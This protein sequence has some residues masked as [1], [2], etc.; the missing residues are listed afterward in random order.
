MDLV[1]VPSLEKA[2]FGVLAWASSLYTAEITDYGTFCKHSL[3]VWKCLSCTCVAKPAEERHGNFTNVAAKSITHCPPM[4]I[5][6]K[7]K[8]NFVV[9]KHTQVYTQ[10]LSWHIVHFLYGRKQGTKHIRLGT[11]VGLWSYID[12]IQ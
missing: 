4:C 5:T 8:H 3:G 9:Q 2:A 10:V 12:L 7:F 1:Y 6:P 11:V